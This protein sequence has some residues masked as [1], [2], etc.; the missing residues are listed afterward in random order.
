M[1]TKKWLLIF[2]LLCISGILYAISFP[3]FTNL[4]HENYGKIRQVKF[5]GSVNN[6]NFIEVKKGV[7]YT[8]EVE[9][10]CTES[11]NVHV[12]NDK[13]NMYAVL[14]GT[15]LPIP[16]CTISYITSPI[17]KN[18]SYKCYFT[19]TLPQDFPTYDLAFEYILYTSGNDEI[20]RF[21]VPVSIK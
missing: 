20:L 7:G 2:T 13:T 11:T 18:K 21:T 15:R 12:L 16:S 14:L 6:K 19:F 3:E 8:I 10:D 17:E 1:K 4:N 5:S 9:F